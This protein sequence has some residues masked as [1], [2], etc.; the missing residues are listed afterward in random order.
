MNVYDNI[1]TR[2]LQKV[3]ERKG[4]CQQSRVTG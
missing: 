3:L 2:S 1:S 4:I